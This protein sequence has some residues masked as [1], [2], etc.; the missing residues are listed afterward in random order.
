ML[1]S[2]SSAQC[3]YPPLCIGL[4]FPISVLVFC[5]LFEVSVSAAN[6]S[7]SKLRCLFL[8]ALICSFHV[9]FC[10]GGCVDCGS[11]G[12]CGG[13]GGCVDI[14]TV[15]LSA[16]SGVSDWDCL[17]DCLCRDGDSTAGSILGSFKGQRRRQSNTFAFFFA[18]P[19]KL[20]QLRRSNLL[21]AL[22]N[23]TK[24]VIIQ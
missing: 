11:R 20:F 23:Q 1:H 17:V 9:C 10:G 12:D 19:E 5:A 8:F 15:G 6:F 2:Y 14:L 13:C 16:I 7:A 4:P 22:T 18:V 21:V 3:R 24:S